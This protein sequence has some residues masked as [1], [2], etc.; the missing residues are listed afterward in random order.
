MSVPVWAGGPQRHRPGGFLAIRAHAMPAHCIAPLLHRCIGSSTHD[1]A[2][3]RELASQH[4]LNER[5]KVRRRGCAGG[6]PVVVLCAHVCRFTNTYPATPNT[7]GIIINIPN[8]VL[9]I[10]SQFLYPAPFPLSDGGR[11]DPDHN[12]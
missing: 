2:A 5:L 8:T 9:I 7:A 3:G 1:T 11:G 6:R 4:E 10:V 12:D